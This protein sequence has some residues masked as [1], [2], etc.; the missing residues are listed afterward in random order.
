MGEL[1]EPTLG[2]SD[3]MVEVHAVSLSYMDCLMVSGQYQMRPP[4]P[5]APGTD[6]AGVVIDAGKDVTR[7]RRGDRIACGDFVGAF[8]ERIAVNEWQ[9]TGIPDALSFEVASTVRHA[10]GTA[11][12]A[13]VERA[14]LQ[15]GETVF[16]TGAAGGTGLASVDLAVHLG[17][18]VIAGI[19]ADDKVEVVQRYGAAAVL[20]YRRDDI[21][22]KIKEFTDG[23]GIDVCFETVGGE[24]FDQMTRLMA[25]NG[26]LMPIG[27]A[28]GKIPSVP[29]NLP[30]L[31][32]YSIVGV[33][34]G[35]WADMF[36]EEAAAADERLMQWV[37]LGQLRPHVS[38]M[39]PLEQAAEAMTSVMDR[40]AQGR[41]VLRTR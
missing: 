23:R 33:F 21:R 35:A 32:N 26:R 34:N 4:L 2:P 36:P 9:G 22:A 25:W 14:R 12:Y 20:N 13:L 19:G 11:W 30:L 15:A 10:Y 40:T 3:V 31:K 5:F 29:M 1:P 17:A 16:I 8:A 18:K 6:A 28:G 7:F 24:L 41:V 37:G 39:L 27:F 38:R